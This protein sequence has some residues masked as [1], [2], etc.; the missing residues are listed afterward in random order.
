MPSLLLLLLLLQTAV[1]V[2]DGDE[3]VL[4]LDPGSAVTGNAVATAVVDAFFSSLLRLFELEN[5]FL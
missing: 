4:V 3:A 2:G 1:A 5:H